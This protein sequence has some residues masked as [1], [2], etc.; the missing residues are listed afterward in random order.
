MCAPLTSSA[1]ASCVQVQQESSACQIQVEGG[2]QTFD[3]G[4]WDPSALPTWSYTDAT[5][6]SVTFEMSGA[7]QC[8]AQPGASQPYTTTVILN[9]A[10]TQSDL[11]V[12]A[13]TGTSCNA[14]YTMSTPLA[15]KGGSPSGGGAAKKGL[16][17]GWVFIIILIVVF[18]LYVIGGCVYKSQKL[19]S[20]GMEKCPNVEFWRDR[21]TNRK[22]KKKKIKKRKKKK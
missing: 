7:N 12:T 15:C 1:A 2:T 14:V 17:G 19:G 22:K 4:N 10:K 5:K 8:W 20:T 18:P 9:C 21:Q 11:I 16:S 3:I 13:P 6:Q